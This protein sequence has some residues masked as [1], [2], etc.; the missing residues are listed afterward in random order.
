[1]KTTNA[2]KPLSPLTIE[3]REKKETALF[4]FLM[5]LVFS[6]SPLAIDMYLPALPAMATHFASSIDAMEATV[7]VYLLGFA[8]GQ[9]FFGTI[10]DS[11]DKRKLMLFGLFGFAISSFF[12]GNSDSQTSL[13]FWRAMQ[14]FTSGSSVVVFAM[15]QQKY[16]NDRDGGAQRSSQ[17]ISYIMSAVVVAPM[18]APIIGSSLLLSFSW[19]MI[20][21]VLG[22]FALLA[23]CLQLSAFK[24][25]PVSEPK[26]LKLGNLL[27]GYKSI[28]SNKV[29]LAF[30]LAGGFSFAGLFSFI[31]GS[32]YVYMEYFNATPDQFAWLV[33]LNAISMITMNLVNAKVL[34]KVNPTK[35]LIFGGAAIFLVSIYLLVVGLLNLPLPFVVAGV[36]MYVG[37]LGFTS[38]NAIAGALTS[39]KEYAGLLSGINGVI[40]FGIGAG[41]SALISISASTSAMT[42]NTTMASCGALCFI[43]T[44][45]LL[46]NKLIQ[47][48]QSPNRSAQDST[49]QTINEGA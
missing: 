35:K 44:L 25:L 38:A 21:Y 6:L 43:C 31:A 33:A 40:Q 22:A 9:L 36:V 42:M 18:V 45:F 39:A 19:S 13:Y 10:A 11:L 23:L 8:L 1:M 37:C 16:R 15:V 20:F 4:V 41:A 17:T 3:L 26:T 2:I 34:G 48:R 47:G 7:A 12:I 32:P 29:T 27:K 46:K 24:I 14:A 28:F 49:S 5:T 30:V